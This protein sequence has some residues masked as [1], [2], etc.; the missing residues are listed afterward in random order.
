MTLPIAQAPAGARLRDPMNALNEAIFR[1]LNEPKMS[2]DLGD[3]PVEVHVCQW[4]ENNTPFPYVLFGETQGSGGRE[5][6][7]W[8]SK[9]SSG[10]ELVTVLDIWSKYK[11]MK[12]V[13]SIAAL[14]I[15]RMTG[16]K[17]DLNADG[18]NVAMHRLENDLTQRMPDGL[19]VRRNLRFRFWIQD[20]VSIQPH[21]GG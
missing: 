20:Q 1:R 6:A 14:V 12:E 17:L 18:F 15:D 7:Q 5:G 13:N 4:H 16:D 9:T 3:G 2:F 21:V 8:T 19:T 10:W 11:G